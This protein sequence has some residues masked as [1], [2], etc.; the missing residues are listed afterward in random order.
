VGPASPEGDARPTAS[1]SDFQSRPVTTSQIL[2]VNIQPL[3]ISEAR[4]N[5]FGAC[6]LLGP[7]RRDE[8][9]DKEGT[10]PCRPT[11]P[12]AGA[13]CVCGTIE[14]TEFTLMAIALYMEQHSKVV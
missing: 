3:P 5:L 7:Q 9:G 8:S 10:R 13:I 14:G 12:G 11:A 4:T 2:S 6:L 1:R